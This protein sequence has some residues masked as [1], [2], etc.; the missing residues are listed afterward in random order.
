MVN[1]FKIAIAY[2]LFW[3]G[4][5]W[6]QIFKYTPKYSYLSL[7]KLF[8]STNGRFN[9]KISLRI[10][11]K[12]GEYRIE[13][14][15]QSF[16]GP[17]SAEKINEISSS[18]QR[19]GY[20]KFNTLLDEKTINDLV[21]YSFSLKAKL[22]PRVKDHQEF[23]FFVQ[24][25][26]ITVKYE[27]SESELIQNDTIQNLVSDPGLL[28]IAQSFLGSKPILDMISMWWS[29]SFSQKASSEVA[30]LYHFDMERLKF[31]KI[32]FYLTDVDEERGPHCYVRGSNNGFSKAVQKDGRI[33]DDE[34]KSN[35][36]PQDILEITGPRGTILAVDTSGFHKGK[37]L[38]KD[39]RLLLQF[40]FANSLFG[41]ENT[42]YKVEKQSLQFQ[43]SRRTY[44]HIF[45]RYS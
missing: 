2:V 13:N 15:A 28:A 45:Q 42:Y 37:N 18:V 24:D 6:Y 25:N 12:I 17:L 10:G 3:F 44:P 21:S 4:Y 41:V 23:D 43:E 29:T 26:P 39:S 30:Q 11:Q 32:F 14:K 38:S 33:S 5:Y 7:R 34:I 1:T 16:L 27:Y 9:R 40:E 35:Y 20:Y 22:M 36:P 8:Y 31:L 19:D